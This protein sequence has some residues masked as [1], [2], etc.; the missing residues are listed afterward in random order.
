MVRTILFQG[1]SITDCGR[2]RANP[3]ALGPGYPS[4]VATRIV[5]NNWSCRRNFIN[6]GI[7]GDRVVDL[8][9]R[10]KRDAINLKPDVISILIG[11]N[12]TWHEM[13]YG[14]GVEPERYDRFYRM[15]LDWSRKSNPDVKFILLE[16]FV[17]NFGFITSEWLD[18]IKERQEIVRKIAADYNAIFVPLQ[19]KISA[20]ADMARDPKMVLGDGVH[21]TIYGHQLIADE[22][23]KYAGELFK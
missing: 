11:V 2:D 7:S 6:R 23:L 13:N 20:A 21:P 12:D 5:N 10:W 16:P 9:A 22:Y 4:M 1:D 18:E 14:N 17:L 15:L 3:G 8:Y 19:E